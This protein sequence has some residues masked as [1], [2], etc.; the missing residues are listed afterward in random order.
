MLG[1]IDTVKGGDRR[2][3]QKNGFFYNDGKEQSLADAGNDLFTV[4]Q[5]N[6]ILGGSGRLIS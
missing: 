3:I 4:L 6:D 5:R 1:G 2:Q